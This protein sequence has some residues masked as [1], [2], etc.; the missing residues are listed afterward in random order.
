[1][2]LLSSFQ[3]ISNTLVRY[4]NSANRAPKPIHAY[5]LF[6]FSLQYQHIK[7]EFCHLVEKKSSKYFFMDKKSLNPLPIV[8]SKSQI[9]EYENIQEALSSAIQV[10]VLNYFRDVRIQSA[11]KLD[12]KV[13]A[14]L[15]LYRDKS[16]Y[17]IGSYR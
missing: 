10:I 11:L 2:K 17:Q 3:I 5:N 13:K 15:E 7:N 8:I 14:I 4:S 12:T 6:K 1:M 9:N 16:F